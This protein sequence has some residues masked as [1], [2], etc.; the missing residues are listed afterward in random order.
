MARDQKASLAGN[1][2]ILPTFMKGNLT[3]TAILVGTITIMIGSVSS[4][5]LKEYTKENF[6]MDLSMAKGFI[7]L[8]IVDWSMRVN[9]AKDENKEKES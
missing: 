9:T 8:V 1:Q 6:L 2:T 5:R 7:N 3:S 4:L